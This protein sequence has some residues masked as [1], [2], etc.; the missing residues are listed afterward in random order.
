MDVIAVQSYDFVNSKYFVSPKDLVVVFSHRGTKTFST[1]AIEVAVGH[2]GVTTVLITGMGTPTFSN[3]DIRIETPM[4]SG[5][6]WH[7]LS[8]SLPP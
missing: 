8:R 1:R 5:K 2:F 4:S 7:L 6:L 3:A